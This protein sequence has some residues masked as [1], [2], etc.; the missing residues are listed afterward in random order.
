VLFT[1]LT[2]YT[3]RVASTDRA[4]LRRILQEHEEMVRPI[5]EAR[6]GRVVKNIGDSFLC[7]FPA[8]T[9]ALRA[10]LEIQARVA[11]L[12]APPIRVAVS[13]G[14]VE[15]IDGDA[16]GEPV[17]L[18]SRIL[19]VTP[20]GEVWFATGTHA[21]MNAAEVPWESVG[22]L[23]LRGIPGEQE[24]FRAVPRQRA[25]LPPELTE[26]AA[27]R[28]LVRLRPGART[29]LL[30]AGARVLIE[31]FEP[32]SAALRE[33]IAALPVLEPARLFL[34]AYQLSMAQREEWAESGRGLLVGTEQAIDD[35]LAEAMGAGPGDPAFDDTATMLLG[36]TVL[37][38]VELAV[39][40]LALPRVPFADVVASY[41]YDLLPDGLWATR[42]SQAL[43]RVLVQP[44][45]AL[46]QA[47]A[48]GIAVAGRTVPPGRAVALADG[49]EV[50]TPAG[51][52]RFLATDRVYLGVL[53]AEPRAHLAVGVGQTAELGRRPN[54]PGL[55]FPSLEGQ[56]NLRW[57]A[58]VKAERARA[59]NFTFDRAL[60]GR[61]QAAVE[62]ASRRYTVLPLHETCPTYLVRDGHVERIPEATAVR[63][64]DLLVAG[65]TA[66]QLSAPH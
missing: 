17:N 40:G 41:S 47:L 11:D 46:V 59:Q 39:R 12:R 56:D 13:T 62:V 32:G 18:A 5:V 51:T 60:T 19:G 20:A 25:W 48:S 43:L 31:G 50:G 64:G 21:C 53:L 3:A 45:T 36:A 33:A 16:F 7:L 49:V 24:C 55:A 30:P 8:A 61:R 22:R 34:A 2:D 6:G 58:G 1:D 15:E 44:T 37:P 27:Q 35:A 26:A 4:G 65:T 14:D 54:P 57:C 29:P 52:L 63:D 28:R 23:R 66:V 42:S 10:G 9:D 38:E